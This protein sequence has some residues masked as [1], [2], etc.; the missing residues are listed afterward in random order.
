MTEVASLP[1]WPIGLTMTK[2]ASITRTIQTRV[3]LATHA[4]T[5]TPSVGHGSRRVQIRTAPTAEM[6]TLSDPHRAPEY[7]QIHNTLTRWVQDLCD[8]RGVEYPTG[9]MVV[10]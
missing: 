5:S 10:K 3:P 7:Q 2:M 9:G 4:V 6:A 1:P 8:S